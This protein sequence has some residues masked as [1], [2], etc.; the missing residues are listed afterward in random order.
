M[1]RNRLR[2]RSTNTPSRVA[3]LGAASRLGRVA[4]WKRP[5]FDPAQDVLYESPGPI[6]NFAR[7]NEELPLDANR[8][9]LERSYNSLSGLCRRVLLDQS[10]FRSGG[11]RDFASC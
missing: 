4:A 1:C 7:L 10:F 6:P 8:H 2:R 11:Y 5:P 9:F 3:S